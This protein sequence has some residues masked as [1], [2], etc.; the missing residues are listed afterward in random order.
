VNAGVP[1]AFPKTTIGLIDHFASY[2]DNPTEQDRPL[3]QSEAMELA[4]RLPEK[5]TRMD[6]LNLVTS[7]KSQGH[8]FRIRDDL[9]DRLSAL[10][11]KLMATAERTASGTT[12]AS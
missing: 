1:I 3:F 11:T 5:E 6:F 2:L 4:R 7:L 8:A 9:R 10:R 12:V